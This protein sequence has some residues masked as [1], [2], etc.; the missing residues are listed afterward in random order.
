MLTQR[1][2]EANP[3]KINALLEMSSS[4]KPREVISLTG[5]VD[6]LSHFVPQAT[7]CCAAFFDMLKGS[8]KF[9]W[10]DRYK[11]AFLTLKEH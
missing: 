5:R 2:I 9:E 1:G 6:T 10:I 8:N 3:K 4:K 7:D 11:Q